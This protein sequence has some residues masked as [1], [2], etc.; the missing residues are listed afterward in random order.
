MPFKFT[1]GQWGLCTILS[2]LVSM[3]SVICMLWLS[4][5]LNKNYSFYYFVADSNHILAVVTAICSFMFFKNL[6]IKPSKLINTIGASTFG[7]LLIH[8]NS[9]TMR[10][11][12][13]QDVL[14]NTA[15]FSLPFHSLLAHAIFGV[16]GIFTEVSQ[17]NIHSSCGIIFIHSI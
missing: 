7:V 9:D 14:N 3:S 8:A 15:C 6:K 12:L 16:L 1:N 2:I 13:W 4:V 11:W 10:H 17:V 5:K